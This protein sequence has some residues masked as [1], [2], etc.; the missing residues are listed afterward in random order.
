MNILFDAGRSHWLSIA[1]NWLTP[2]SSDKFVSASV[3]VMP[4]KLESRVMVSEKAISP[5]GD[6]IRDQTQFNFVVREEREWQ[7]EIQD[8][9]NK[10]VRQFSGK[11]TPSVPINWLGKD[12]SQDIVVDGVYDVYL[13][14]V[15]QREIKQQ[16][17][18]KAQVVI[19]TKPISFEIVADPIILTDLGDNKQDAPTALVVHTKI[20]A[21]IQ[22]DHSVLQF[23]A[24]EDLLD[25]VEGQGNP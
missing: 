7:L 6:G 12:A 4:D 3:I 10:I 14:G 9:Q 2:T 16:L 21:P 20:S 22:V 17:S 13:L 11:G 1:V 8:R 24:G 23:F 25:E 5:N 18:S 19:D 15:D